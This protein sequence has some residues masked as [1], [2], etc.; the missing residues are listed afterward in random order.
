MSAVSSS[1]C[2]CVCVYVLVTHEQAQAAAAIHT[3]TVATA[4]QRRRRQRT[5][6]GLRQAACV[7]PHRQASLASSTARASAPENLL[8]VCV[9]NRKSI[10]LIDSYSSRRSDANAREGTDKG[11]YT[12]CYASRRSDACSRARHDCT[13]TRASTGSDGHRHTH[14]GHRRAAAQAATGSGRLA[15]AWQAAA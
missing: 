9:S 8:M 12:P 7:L 11:K 4:E 10:I 1:Q 2:V 14:R 13:H 6:T 5:A 15:A 3:R